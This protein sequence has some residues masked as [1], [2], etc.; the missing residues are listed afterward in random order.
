MKM[1]A[2]FHRSSSG[3]ILSLTVR[4]KQNKTKNVTAYDGYSLREHDIYSSVTI[5]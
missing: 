1:S 2:G 4:S 3:I 5:G